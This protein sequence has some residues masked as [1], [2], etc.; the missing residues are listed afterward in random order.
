MNEEFSNCLY[1]SANNLSKLLSGVADDAFSITGL[2]PSYAFLLMAVNN[3]P[4][5]QPSQLSEILRLKPSTITRL[6]EKM[7]YQGFLERKSEGR[8]TH[9][10][11]TDKSQDKDSDL[12]EAW[13]QLKDQYSSILGDRYT[14]V[15][16]EMSVKAVDQL[17]NNK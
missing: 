2:A 6:I 4:G 5:L 11:P 17:E 10:F 1:Y 12:R 13:Q 9:V 15:L 8:A 3:D 7:E 14:E 16:T